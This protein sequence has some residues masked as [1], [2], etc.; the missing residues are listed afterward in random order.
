MQTN[1]EAQSEI[2]EFL[3]KVRRGLI[4]LKEKR[5]TL[6]RLVHEPVPLTT[7]QQ[8]N[9]FQRIGSQLHTF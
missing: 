9:H 2:D 1:D 5:V 7:G 3:L 8:D 4:D 6:V